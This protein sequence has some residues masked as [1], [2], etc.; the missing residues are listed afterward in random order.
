MNGLSVAT[1]SP[2]D[3]AEVVGVS[4]S[5]IKRWVDAGLIS[6]SRTAGGHR[7]IAVSEALRFIRSRRM[8]IERPDRLGIPDLAETPSTDA[9]RLSADFLFNLL[10][11]G[12]TDQARRA[13]TASFSAGASA[14]ELFDGPITGALERIGRIWKSEQ[15]G[16]LVE[17]SATASIIE[18][19]GQLSGLLPDSEET[20]PLAVGGAPDRDPHIL[21]SLMASVVAA[22]AGWRTIN[23][24]PATPFHTFRDAAE[25]HEPDLIWIAA[26]SRVPRNAWEELVALTSDL[27]ASGTVV[28]L[29]GHAVV[30]AA[31]RWPKGVHVLTSMSD[32]S[33]LMANLRPHRR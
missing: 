3:L 25:E 27:A 10:E 9:K 24:G 28:A 18:G 1:L 26:K 20:A 14:A 4:E 30:G 23:L 22:E 32:L 5:S 7:R 31:V 2:K 13:I 12:Y 17:H 8:R 15:R 11:S 21:P 16:I 29:G 6:V 19:I 33:G